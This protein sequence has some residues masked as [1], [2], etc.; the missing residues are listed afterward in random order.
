MTNL[1]GLGI[2]VWELSH[3]E[4]G[5]IDAIITKA[6]R[7]GVSWLCVKAG[8]K[9]SNGQVTKALVDRLR[10]SGIDCAAWWYSHPS[11]VD[12]ELTYLS[13][14][15]TKAGIRHLI[16]DAEEPWEREPTDWTKTHD[17]RHEAASYASSLRAA[18]GPDVYL[19]DAPWARPKSH[20]GPFPYAEFGDVMDARH[21]QLYWRLAE[22]GGETYDRFIAQAD[23][24][25][26][27]RAPGET[28]CPVGSTVDAQG[29]T[30]APL[31]E[32]GQFLDR[33][34]ARPAVSLW[35]W[36]HLNAAEWQ[37]LEERAN[38]QR[39]FVEP[40]EPPMTKPKN[41]PGTV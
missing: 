28:I 20:G 10:A 24:Q 35:S 2:W 39:L 40:T 29:I 4:R 30:H 38:K 34:A 6:Q 3:C 16:M 11:S 18:V 31:A 17:W 5:N 25:W 33:Y 32:L 37:L 23:L 19:A 22:V 13:D 7:C 14:L 41:D 15:V 26:A 1:T 36:Q 21:P 9:T 27:E 8:D 12:S